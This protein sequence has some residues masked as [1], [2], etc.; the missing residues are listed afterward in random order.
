MKIIGPNR[1]RDVARANA[2]KY[3]VGEEIQGKPAF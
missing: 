3:T 1:I 2:V